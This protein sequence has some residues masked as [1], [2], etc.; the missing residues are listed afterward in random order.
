MSASLSHETPVYTTQLA[1]AGQCFNFE[2]GQDNTGR[3]YLRCAEVAN[4]SRQQS[5]PITV[6]QDAVQPF[7]KA[8]AYA[9]GLCN[10]KA[11]TSNIDQI[12]ITY[13]RAYR[14][15]TADEDQ[16][17]L[18]LFKDGADVQELATRFQRQPS[19]I[20]SRLWKL[21]LRSL[22]RQNRSDQK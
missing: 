21:S 13:P 15:W 8:L 12:R 22:Q 6:F 16:E 14:G 10:P 1:V 5:Q 19:A 7:A 3:Y 9:A 4:D 2:V 11:K 17:L 18:N 20:E